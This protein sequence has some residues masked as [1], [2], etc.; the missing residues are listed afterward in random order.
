MNTK[1]ITIIGG[2]NLGVSLANG[3]IKSEKFDNGN[4]TVT[5]RRLNLI[6]HLNDHGINLSSDNCEAV[7]NA[8]VV[9][10]AVKPYQIEDI[11]NEIKPNITPNH[12]VVSLATGFT[13]KKLEELLGEST[14]VV[15]AMPNTAMSIGESMTCVSANGN[16]KGAEE[17]VNEFFKE[18]GHSMIINEELMPSATVL[19]S[20]GI[21]FA[22][23]FLRAMSQG[24]IEIGFG[25]HLA[26][27]IAAQT[28]KGAASLVQQEESHPEAEI[29][30]VT[31]P[32][33]ITISGLNEMEHCGFSSALI[34]GLMAS[35]KKIER[36]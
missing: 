35:F 18:F 11:I 16:A 29:D 28:L 1:K 33:G 30:K 21:A 36:T 7:K 25:S 13:L 4:I 26:H 19:A 10:L 12:I 14:K 5:R 15:R 22:L 31:T 24:G 34:Q 9:I 2:G 17:S 3:L 32:Q 20:C 6:S 23:R 8:D 27:Q